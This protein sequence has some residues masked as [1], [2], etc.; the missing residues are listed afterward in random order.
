[1][2]LS[3]MIVAKGDGQEVCFQDGGYF[4]RFLKRKGINNHALLAIVNLTP[5]PSTTFSDVSN[6]VTSNEITSNRY[7]LSNCITVTSS[8][9]LVTFTALTTLN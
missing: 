6:F 4:S 9:K 7:F 8:K 5:N 2:L 3:S 1:M